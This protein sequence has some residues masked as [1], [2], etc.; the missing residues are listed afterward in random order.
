M[1]PVKS[2]SLFGHDVPEWESC[3]TTEARK[4]LGDLALLK[5]VDVPTVT[6]E[7]IHTW[8]QAGVQRA[9]LFP[10]GEDA[11]LGKTFGSILKGDKLLNFDEC[12]QVQLSRE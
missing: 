3:L 12:T 11:Y 6:L 7:A 5:V 8:S 1:V 10:M 2:I 4:V 9:F